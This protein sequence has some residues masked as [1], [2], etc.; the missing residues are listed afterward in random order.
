M[1]HKKKKRG[2]CLKRRAPL[3]ARLLASLNLN[4]N[5]IGD[6]GA[7]AIAEAIKVNGALTETVLHIGALTE[8]DLRTNATGEEAKA[9]R[10]VR[11]PLARSQAL[12][13][14]HNAQRNQDVLGPKVSQTFGGYLWLGA[15]AVCRGRAPERPAAWQALRQLS[16]SC[17]R[18][19]RG[20][21]SQCSIPEGDGSAVGDDRDRARG[22]SWPRPDVRALRSPTT[23]DVEA[24]FCSI[25]IY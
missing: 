17:R 7:K 5:K 20:V 1:A 13:V 23:L 12:R 3:S 4:W 22:A 18:G 11:S 15:E 6:Q 8:V 25:L 2:R 14:A 24:S 9:R 21:R 10:C 19:G 16:D